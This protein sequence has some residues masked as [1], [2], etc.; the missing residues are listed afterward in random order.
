MKKN[1]T[2]F[3]TL[4]MCIVSLYS[5]KK[6]EE[7]VIYSG[8]VMIYTTLD[9]P[10]I[11]AIKTDFE[12]IYPG[13]VLDYYYGDID[14]I[15]NKLDIEYESG[16][17]NTDVVFLANELNL[18]NLKQKSMITPYESKELKKISANYKEQN[19]YYYA[20]AVT[21][22]GIGYNVSEDFGIDSKS[23][24]KTWNDFLNN[25]YSGKMALAN[26]NNDSYAKYWVMAMMQNQNYSDTYFRRLR[27][28]GLVIK[29]TENEV[30]D[31]LLNGSYKVGLCYD[32]NSVGLIS[33]YDDFKFDYANSDNVT[34]MTG[35]AL[36]SD[37]LND[38][39]AKLLIDYILSKR[40]QELLVS[41]GL[42]S[43]RTDV[44]NVLNSK[45]IIE[46]S[47]KVDL[48]DIKDNGEKYLATFN[49][50]FGD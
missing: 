22:M 19:N 25:D 6:K 2:I 46:K 17:I 39:N 41:Q 20:G 34:M 37:A 36:I 4:L 49:D 12:N 21:T 27:D 16:Q 30:V 23:A 43:A 45:S 35:L 33:E 32:E 29:N 40:C 50:I 44:K 7:P 15:N 9:E 38:T 48:N 18:E 10:V 28:Y 24:P 5:C 13:V 1:F 8:S 14:R 26:P 3:L 31:N 47:I 11:K 42:I